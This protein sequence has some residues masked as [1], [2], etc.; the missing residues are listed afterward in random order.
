M[1]VIAN[2]EQYL[3]QV[4]RTEK[5]LREFNMSIARFEKLGRD[6]LNYVTSAT[7]QSSTKAMEDQLQETNRLAAVIRKSLQVLENSQK[8]ATSSAINSHLHQTQFTRLSH[9]FMNLLSRYQQSQVRVRRNQRSRLERQYL[10]V[11]PKASSDE[12]QTILDN[13]I[14]SNEIFQQSLALSSTSTRTDAIRM[15]ENV[16]ERH[17]S[18]QILAQ[19]IE[20]LHQLYVDMQTLT[21]NQDQLVNEVVANIDTS[22]VNMEQTKKQMTLAVRNKRR[23]RRKCIIISIMM[24]LLL[25]IGGVIVYLTYFHNKFNGNN[26]NA[27]SMKNPSTSAS[28][29]AT[30]SLAFPRSTPTPTLIDGHPK[31]SDVAAESSNEPE[32]DG[33]VETKSAK[34]PEPSDEAETAEEVTTAGDENAETEGTENEEGKEFDKTEETTGDAS[35][36]EESNAS[37]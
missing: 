2:S 8:S 34:S 37:E 15:L 18:I 3:E 27:S 17:E 24:L 30:S 32:S 6:S 22:K 16:N 20:E 28:P 33:S 7:T 12:V 13:G 4:R 11:N 31:A 14:S 9:N 5:M 35:S 25:I 29:V 19:S 21:Q 36:E 26:G 10:I 1:T 23:A